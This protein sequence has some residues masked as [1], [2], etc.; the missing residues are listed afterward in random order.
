MS[1]FTQLLEAVKDETLPLEM[2][3]KYRDEMIHLHSAMQ[4]ELANIEKEEAMYFLEWNK[5]VLLGKDDNKL[6]P[7]ADIAIKR[8]WR[9][10]DKGQ[11]GIELN[12]YVKVIAKEIDSLKSRVYRLI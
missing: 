11:R 4:I 8:M 12:R 1:Q 9:G 7:I 10:T 6:P 5:P 3:E 2:I